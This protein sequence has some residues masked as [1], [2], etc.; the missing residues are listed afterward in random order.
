ME[1]EKVE[2]E[3]ETFT[4]KTVNVNG[5]EVPIASIKQYGSKDKDL[6]NSPYAIKNK[7]MA[8]W[9]GK[10]FTPSTK[11]SI[12]GRVKVEIDGTEYYFGLSQ[13]AMNEGT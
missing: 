6:M 11:G 9:S 4:V 13:T 7:K 8:L 1:I 5:H 12:A 3:P 2:I 10:K